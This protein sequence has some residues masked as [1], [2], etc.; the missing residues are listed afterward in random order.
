MGVLDGLTAA[1]FSR[2]FLAAFFVTVAT[3]YTLRILFELRQT[4]SSPVS[5]GRRGSR[6]R[7]HQN[8]FRVFRVAILLVCVARAFW[9]AID[10]LLVP[11]PFLEHPAILLSGN[12]LLLLSFA[13]VLYVDRYMAGNWRSGIDEARKVPLIA[14]G[15]FALSRNPVF[16]LVQLG[17]LGLFLALPSL[18]TLVCLVVGIVVIQAQVRLEEAHLQ[19]RHGAA[20]T[21]YRAR[22]PRWLKPAHGRSRMTDERY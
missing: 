14:S 6:H 5:L 15:P 9:P 20:F 8:V 16:L 4:G 19:A 18:F 17:Q 7:L 12:L 22:V 21:A 3:F 11:F 1:G 13:G 2:W 10:P